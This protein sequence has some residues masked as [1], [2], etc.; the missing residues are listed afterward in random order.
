VA[1]TAEP[2]QDLARDKGVRAT[3]IGVKPVGGRLAAIGILIDDGNLR[4]L[5]Q[6]VL[7]LAQAKEGLELSRSLHAAGK[8]VLTI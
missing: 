3:M 1:L 4:P 5:V 8:I 2:P 6:K 7:P